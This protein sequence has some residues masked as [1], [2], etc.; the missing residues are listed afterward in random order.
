MTSLEKIELL[1]PRVDQINGYQIS[2]TNDGDNGTVLGDK[3]E[4]QAVGKIQDGE[5]GTA[6]RLY[7]HSKM[8]SAVF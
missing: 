3:I 6:S 4:I 5:S 8:T 7:H 1:S 2:S